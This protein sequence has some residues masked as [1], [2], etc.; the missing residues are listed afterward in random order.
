MGCSHGGA[1]HEHYE[2][3]PKLGGGSFGEVFI[4]RSR[5]NPDIGDRAVKIIDIGDGEGHVSRR[6]L[7]RVLCEQKVWSLVGRHRHC[8]QF[9]HLFVELKLCKCSMVMEKCGLSFAERLCD[10]PLM[11]EGKLARIFH[12]MLLGIAHIH[13]HRVVHRDVKPHNFLFGGPDECTAKLCDF[14]VAAMVPKQGPMT[15]RRGTVPYMSPEMA[16]NTGHYLNTDVWSM[17]AT[18]YVM[19]YNTL[20]YMPRE[21]SSAAMTLAIVCGTPEPRFTRA[22]QLLPLPS[23]SAEAFVR[24]LLTRRRQH[25][26]S[27]EAALALPFVHA[28]AWRRKAG[29]E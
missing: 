8:V 14:G 27:A 29:E 11:S 2:I 24:S 6:S 25:R 26:C 9:I 1:F 7:D 28:A 3:G 16:G 4:A 21:C 10:F 13:S 23:T 19:L 17:G 5:A 20:P 22:A 18:A 12:E 15:G